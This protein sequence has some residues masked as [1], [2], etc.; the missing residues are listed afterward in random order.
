[1][2]KKILIF[3]TVQGHASIAEAISEYLNKKNFACQIYSYREKFISFYCLIYQYNPSIFVHFY[4]LGDK[5]KFN[6]IFRQLTIKRYKRILLKSILET[7]PDLI[8]STY[9]VFNPALEKIAK[10]LKIP[11]I[12]IVCN[13]WTISPLEISKPALVNCIFDK[14]SQE[15]IKK[16]AFP[17]KNDQNQ[18]KL[19]ITGWFVRKQ[20]QE[21]YNEKQVK[22]SLGL[23]PD[24]LIF[25]FVTGYEGTNV[26]LE[27]LKN[28]IN[29]D[30]EQVK[31][32]AV[33]ILVACGK[34]KKLL[35]KVKALVKQK[36]QKAK[37]ADQEKNKTS[38]G[39]YLIQEHFHLIPIGFTD[40]LYQYM[41]AADLV[42]GKAGPNTLFESVAT[43]TPFFATTHI[44]G[45]ETGNLD[46]IRKH[47]LGFVE[48]NPEQAQKK[49]LE[50]IDQPEMLNKFKPHLKKMAEYNCEAKKKLMEL[51]GSLEV[52]N[53][54]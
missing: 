48:E 32:K 39:S 40:K 43:L 47:N 21:K 41:Q 49:L 22:K 51:I 42:I 18:A 45:Q 37:L 30:S 46:L 2:K 15:E 36:F 11:F 26:I 13:P 38:K 28:L 34:N 19:Q 4:Q 7:K 25:L 20:Y 44:A 10:E 33:Q 29:E 31:N 54:I 12:N 6:K 52:E 53:N 3:S 1:M 9:F 23:D 5:K 8:I 35:K 50:I 24:Q 27:N 14:N 17:S 16:R